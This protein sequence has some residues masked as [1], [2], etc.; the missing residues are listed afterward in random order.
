MNDLLGDLYRWVSTGDHD[1]QIAVEYLRQKLID[2][3]VLVK[4]DRVLMTR[5]EAALSEQVQRLVFDNWQVRQAWKATE[6]V[7]DG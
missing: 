2:G 3:G 4:V 6:E 5:K 1:E 7:D